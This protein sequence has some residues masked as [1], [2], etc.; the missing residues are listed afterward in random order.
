MQ[1]LGLDNIPAITR[2]ADDLSVAFF[3]LTVTKDIVFAKG[4]SLSYR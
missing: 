2:A 4:Q 3:K 1:K